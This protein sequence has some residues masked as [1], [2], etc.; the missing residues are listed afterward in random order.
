M[1]TIP[2]F[3]N[4][5]KK[6]GINVELIANYPWVY[7]DTVNGIRVKGAYWGEHGFTVFVKAARIDQKDQI[8]EIPI[9][10]NKIRETLCYGK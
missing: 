5:L 6:I 4:R 3:I 9:I 1:T 8:L 2:S 10:F 7:L